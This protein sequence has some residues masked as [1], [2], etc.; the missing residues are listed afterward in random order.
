VISTSGRSRGPLK[1]TGAESQLTVCVISNADE[2]DSRILFN[3]LAVT[4]V[5]GKEVYNIQDRDRVLDLHA[6]GPPIALQP[7]EDDNRAQKYRAQLWSFLAATLLVTP[8]LQ[9]GRAYKIVNSQTGTVLDVADTVGK[10]GTHTLNIV[11]IHLQPLTSFRLSLVH[12]L[13]SK[14][15]GEHKVGHESW[16]AGTSRSC[17]RSGPSRGGPR[18]AICSRAPPL[19]ITSSPPTLLRM[20]CQGMG[21]PLSADL[22]LKPRASPSGTSLAPDFTSAK[23]FDNLRDIEC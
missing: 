9:N 11:S 4:L 13:V 17:T 14:G 15:E 8:A 7:V 5:T 6:D 18:T 2:Y 22:N 19:L 23:S 21:Q 3:D 10:P 12:G 16:S 20:I 1:G